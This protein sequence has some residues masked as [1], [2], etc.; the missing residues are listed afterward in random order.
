LITDLV[1]VESIE[2]PRD[3][4]ARFIFLLAIYLVIGAIT[5][6]Y[7]TRRGYRVPASS[8]LSFLITPLFATLIFKFFPKDD[9]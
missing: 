1:T 5:T 8:V 7:G 6:W 9:K 4:V 2:M 3:N